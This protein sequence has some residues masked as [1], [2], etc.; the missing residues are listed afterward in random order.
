[1]DINFRKFRLKD[2]LGE[3][4]VQEVDVQ[5]EMANALY[6]K[7][8]GLACHALALKIYNSEDGAVSLSTEE[9]QLLKDFSEVVMT[10]KFIDS[11]RA[12]AE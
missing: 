5:W 4:A 8:T 7:G 12:Y 11:I 6:D 3:N 1:M 9:F 10:P 2:G